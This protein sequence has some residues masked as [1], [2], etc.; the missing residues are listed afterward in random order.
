[1]K[2]DIDSVQCFGNML[3]ADT[4][5]LE[6]VNTFYVA[7]G[8]CVLAQVEDTVLVCDHHSLYWFQLSSFK[9][10]FLLW[11]P[12]IQNQGLGHCHS[13]LPWMFL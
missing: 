10:V 8:S 5:I 13:T 3:T 11:I 7:K 12:R 4:G 1:M 2:M 6:I 9:Y